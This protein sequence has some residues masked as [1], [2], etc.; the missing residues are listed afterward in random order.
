M[1]KQE[2]TPEGV[3]QV[4]TWLYT[5]NDP[6]LEAEALLMHSDIVGWILNHFDATSAQQ[7]FLNNLSTVFRTVFGAQVSGM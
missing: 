3:D 7:S 2:L 4:V 6:A 5:L 1:E